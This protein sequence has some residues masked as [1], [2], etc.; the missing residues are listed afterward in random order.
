MVIDSRNFP[1]RN[2]NDGGKPSS[3]L[4]RRGAGQLPG[5]RAWLVLLVALGAILAFPDARSA[6]S[7]PTE[8]QVKAAYLYNFGKFVQ[9][10][11]KAAAGNSDSFPIC[12]LGQDPFGKALDSAIVGES[13]NGK[14]VVARR[15]AKTEEA[16]NC[17]VLFI[18]SSESSELGRILSA[19]D[20][21]SLLTV[22][23]MP[24]FAQRGGM[25][26]LLLQDQKVRFEVNLDAARRVG[27]TLSSQLL[28]LAVTVRIKRKSRE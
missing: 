12:V 2:R 6:A 20:D 24:D 26:H 21:A 4:E 18:S 22:S 15:I 28:K 3:R 11:A 9:W 13:I 8:Y 19:L 23:D 27:L 7:T 25:I 16:A 1:A 5:H 17:R 14:N 10:P